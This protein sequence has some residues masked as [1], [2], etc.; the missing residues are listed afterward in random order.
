MAKHTLKT[1][2]CEHLNYVWSF[3]NNMNERVNLIAWKTYISTNEIAFPR[4]LFLKRKL[5]FRQPKI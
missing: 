1:L 3:F 4:K 2:M 5:I